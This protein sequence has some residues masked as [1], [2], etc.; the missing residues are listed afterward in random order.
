MVCAALP[1]RRS[2]CIISRRNCSISG[3][4]PS[5]EVVVERFAGFQ[6]LAV[7]Q[8]RVG[9]RQAVAVFVVI[10]E[11]LQLAVDEAGCC[12]AFRR[13]ARSR[14]SIRRPASDVEVLL[15]TT[16]KHRRHADAGSLPLARTSFRSGHRG[17]TSAVCSSV[18]QRQRVEPCRPCRAP[19]S[20]CPCRCA[21]RGCDRSA[22]AAR[23]VV[24]HRDARQL[25]D[26]ALDGV[27]QRE[28]ADGPGEQR[29]LAIAG[30][31][32]EERRGGQVVDG[33]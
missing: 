22:F 14:R 9:A 6:L 33:A 13:R 12:V 17:H 28:V 32:Q 8:Q 2:R 10:A 19:S 7:D 21:P 25:D 27:H 1:R 3:R 15:H 5:A 4:R 31:A 24:R 30:A 20:A 29:S 26:A 11:Q 18:G 23:Q 16:M